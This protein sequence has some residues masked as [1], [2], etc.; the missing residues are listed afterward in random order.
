MAFPA[1]APTARTYEAGDWPVKT[2]TAISGAEVRI[3][4]GDKRSNAKL[5]L[6][7]DNISDASA[8][9]FLTHYYETTGTFETFTL[10]PEASTGWTGS[11]NAFSP[12]TGAAA[13][14]YAGPPQITSVR[15]GRSSVQVELIGVS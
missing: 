4:Y 1:I 9:Q 12:G 2:Y 3:R 14:R 13:Y 8:E 5:S 11:L 15:P 7:Y 6:S 10:S